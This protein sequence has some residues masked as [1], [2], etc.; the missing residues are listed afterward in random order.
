MSGPFLRDEVLLE[1]MQDIKNQYDKGTVEQKAK[2]MNILLYNCELKGKNT[3]FYWNK[4]FDI[5]F[6]MGQNQKWGE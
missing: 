6:E 3:V 4:P 5:L 1:L 2:I